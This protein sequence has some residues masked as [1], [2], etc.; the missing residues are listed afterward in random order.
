MFQCVS[1]VYSLQLLQFPHSHQSMSFGRPHEWNKVQQN[2]FYLLSGYASFNQFTGKAV[3]MSFSHAS[4]EVKTLCF[5]NL[6]LLPT[7]IVSSVKD[8]FQ[9]ICGL[10][11]NLQ[12]VQII[13]Q[14]ICFS[15]NMSG[16]PR[17][18]SGPIASPPTRYSNLLLGE[19]R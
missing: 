6:L 1:L 18:L 10:L 2:N 17:F 3:S 5:L 13:L 7:G 12:L 8:L 15:D 19:S 11:R 14:G 16:Q 9:T 4:Q